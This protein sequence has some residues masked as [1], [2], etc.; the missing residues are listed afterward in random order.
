LSGSEELISTKIMGAP[1][2][3]DENRHPSLPLRNRM[4]DERA[5]GLFDSGIGGLTVLKS[6]VTSFPQETFIYLGDTARLPYGSKSPETIERYLRQ[7][8]RFLVER[9]VKA[10]VVACN[11]AST[12]L[13][14]RPK[15]DFDFPV[16]VYNVIEPGAETA[17]AASKQKRIGVLGTRAT[18]AAQAYVRALHHID[19]KA[20]VF[21]QACPLLVPLVEEGWD[22]DPLTN[23]V[24]YRYLAPL[25]EQ[26][27]DT[28]ILGCT[29][30][31]ALRDGI[32]RVAGPNIALV[33]SAEAIAARIQSDIQ[34]GHLKGGKAARELILL[35]T[36]ASPGFEEVAARL[37]NPTAIPALQAVDIGA[38]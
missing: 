1:A 21:Q 4:I 3:K 10:V 12:V 22:Q 24:I 9:G 36:D 19:P 2:I 15:T 32:S 38:V 16:P 20:V 35:T 6:L 11:T 5:I 27:V 30:Y 34:Y 18:V 8:I 17:I 14:N 37:M 28:L 7:N 33:D 23:L 31:P 26:K 25:L 13:L 29:H